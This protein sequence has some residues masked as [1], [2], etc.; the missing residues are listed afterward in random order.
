MVIECEEV[1]MGG[2]LVSLTQMYI[3]EHVVRAGE[4][5]GDPTELHHPWHVPALRR[6]P[7][8]NE[9]LQDTAGNV[10]LVG[11]NIICL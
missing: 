10:Y 8:R 1:F 11:Y 2:V 5:D 9:S 4:H 3:D 6:R 7:V